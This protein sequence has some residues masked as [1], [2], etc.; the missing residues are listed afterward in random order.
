MFDKNIIEKIVKATGVKENEVI[1]LHFWGDDSDRHILNTFAAEVSKLGASPLE[2]QQCRNANNDIFKNAS[3]NTFNK[4]YFEC[5]NNVDAVLEIFMH[6]PILLTEKLSKEQANNANKYLQKLF[7]T[8]AT[9]KRFTQIRIPTIENSKDS[10]LNEDDF[11]KRMVQAYNIDYSELKETC[12]NKIEEIKES[13]SIEII[14]ANNNL[15][16]L[17]VQNRNW[18][19]DAGDGDMPCGEIYIAP[20]ENKTNGSIFFKKLFVEDLNSFNDITITIKNGKIESST[21]KEFN[22]F[23]NSLPQNGNVICEFGLGLNKNVHD[24]CGYTVLDEKMDGTFHIAIG[25]NT[26]FG[27]NNDAPLHIDFLGTGEIKFN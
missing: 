13:N 24:L 2:L 8:F 10:N 23:I 5:F 3:E 12:Q 27:G 1:L 22:D 15:L 16:S 11:I 18:I 9:K 17:N 25:N 7:K 26:M 21:N 14:T 20:I 6:P 19:S 4:K